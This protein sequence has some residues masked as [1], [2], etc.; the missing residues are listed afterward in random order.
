[1]TSIIR[2]RFILEIDV[3]VERIATKQE[4]EDGLDKGRVENALF[5]LAILDNPNRPDIIAA[6]DAAAKRFRDKQRAY[7]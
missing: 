7:Q 1:M 6:R 3:L 5:F 2:Q 4:A